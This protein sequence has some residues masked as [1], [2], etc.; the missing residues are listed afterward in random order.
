MSK[1]ITGQLFI[2]CM[3]TGVKHGELL[4][5][6]FDPEVNCL[7]MTSRYCF[8]QDGAR[9][10]RTVDVFMRLEIVFGER[11]I[12]LDAKKFIEHGIE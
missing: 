6:H 12:V 2:D 7:N 10:H 4:E 1:R 11:L 9:S 5:N 8:M 3:V